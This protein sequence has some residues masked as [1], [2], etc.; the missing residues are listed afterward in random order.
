M[1]LPSFA[2]HDFQVM[3]SRNFVLAL[4][5]WLAEASVAAGHPLV[6]GC[7]NVKPGKSLCLASGFSSGHL[8]DLERA[9]AG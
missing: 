4:A 7:L 3:L 8:V 9:F 1:T 6:G 2:T 5:G